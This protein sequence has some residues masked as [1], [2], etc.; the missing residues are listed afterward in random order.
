MGKNKALWLILRR[1]RGGN[2]REVSA[3]NTEVGGIAK[4]Q[5]GAAYSKDTQKRAG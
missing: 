5:A 3:K 1:R 4:H 2:K